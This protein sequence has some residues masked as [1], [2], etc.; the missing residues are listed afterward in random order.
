MITS[1]LNIPA[2]DTILPEDNPKLFSFSSYIFLD[3]DETPLNNN[4][5][6]DQSVSV[7]VTIRYQTNV[8]Q[9]F[10]FFLPWQLKNIILY[11]S[12]IGPMQQIQL[13]IINKPEWADISIAQK[14]VLVEIPNDGEPASEEKTS[15]ILSPYEEAPARPYTITIRATCRQIGRINSFS[16][17]EDIVFTPTFEPTVTIIPDKPMRTVAPR[18]T[19]N[20]NIKIKNEANKKARITPTLDI[21]YSSKD[22]SA[23]INPPYFDIDA[24]Q[25]EEF[26]F[27]IYAPYDF[28]WHNEIGEFKIDFTTEIFPLNPTSPKGGPYS[29]YFRL[30]NYGFSTPGFE[31][32]LLIVSI[33]IIGI[34]I[35][36]KKYSK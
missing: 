36:K 24:G 11:G 27:S 32:L 16:T 8:P 14:D 10:L 6:L 15:L 9:N 21:Q 25:Q 28:G 34:I 33:S 4:L 23:L 22:W 2:D 31:I 1:V 3:F 5:A 29:I 19:V 20:F 13:E 30:N 18:E 12:M 26:V 17:S 35:K 7:P